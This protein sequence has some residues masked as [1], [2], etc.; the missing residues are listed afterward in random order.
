M[1]GSRRKEPGR[2]A[3][4]GGAKKCGHPRVGARHFAF[5]LL[6]PKVHWFFDDLRKGF[7][8]HLDPKNQN[9]FFFRGILEA[10]PAPPCI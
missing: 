6:P 3:Q 8:V 1:P 9:T 2:R 10:P 5:L 4:K 7:P